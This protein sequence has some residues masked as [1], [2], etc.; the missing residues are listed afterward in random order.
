MRLT[1]IIFTKLFVPTLT[2]TKDAHCSIGHRFIT[3]R[4]IKHRS[5][6][7]RSITH[8]SITHCSITHCHKPV[9]QVWLGLVFFG[10]GAGGRSP[11][12]GAPTAPY[13]PSQILTKHLWCPIKR[14]PIE[15]CA[16]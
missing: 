3:H 5:I 8:R 13:P 1:E 15:Q 10:G 14:C 16:S 11:P 7:H 12:C 9:S 6:T 2:D 4:S